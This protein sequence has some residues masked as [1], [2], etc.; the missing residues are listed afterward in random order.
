MTE[1]S[2]LVGQ[3][4]T[5]IYNCHKINHLLFVYEMK[6]LEILKSSGFLAH[7]LGLAGM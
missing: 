7:S 3:N 6:F 2:L 4:G 5:W 1:K